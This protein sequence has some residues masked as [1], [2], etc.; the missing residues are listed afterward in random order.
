MA[1]IRCILP[2]S[3]NFY[4]NFVFEMNMQRNSDDFVSYE[5]NA[6]NTIKFSSRWK[7]IPII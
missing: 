7:S 6:M 3:S 5:I 1:V 2:S 4:Y